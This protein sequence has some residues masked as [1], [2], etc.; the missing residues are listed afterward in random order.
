M[1]AANNLSLTIFFEG[2][3]RM[4]TNHSEAMTSTLFS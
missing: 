1:K 3:W 4:P 2:G